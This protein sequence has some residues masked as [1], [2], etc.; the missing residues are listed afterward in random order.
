MKIESKWLTRCRVTNCWKKSCRTKRNT[1]KK[2]VGLL[3]EERLEYIGSMV[4]GLN[5]ALVELTGALPGLALAIQ[6]TP[7]VA[8][9]GIVTGT[10]AALPIAASD[11]LARKS[12]SN[13]KNPLKSALHTGIAYIFTVLISTFPY[14]IFVNP[15]VSLSV[16]VINV[17]LVISVFI[18]FVKGMPKTRRP[19]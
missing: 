8:L 7:V 2:L 4:L 12:E 13:G 17:V 18:F 5:S 15:F 9:S 3:N 1:R 11:Y 14:L 16:T 19:I 10:A 6:K